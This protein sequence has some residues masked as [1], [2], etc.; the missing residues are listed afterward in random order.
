MQNSRSWIENDVIEV[1]IK[2][3]IE[4]WMNT[5]CITVILELDEYFA[6]L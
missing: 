6:M 3:I 2:Y 4:T 1:V 5:L